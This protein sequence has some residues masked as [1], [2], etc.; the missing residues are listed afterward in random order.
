MQRRVPR[1]PV[2]RPPQRLAVD[3]QHPGAILPRIVDEAPEG[4]TKGR[5]VQQAA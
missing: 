3:G 2:E 5:R 1:R 4:L